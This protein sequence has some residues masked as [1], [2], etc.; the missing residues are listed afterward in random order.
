MSLNACADQLVLA[1]AD[2][3]TITSVTRLSRDPEGSTLWRAA[4]RVPFNHG[5]AEEV[6]RDRPD[7][8]IAGAYTTPATRALL[9][10]LHFPLL[11][12]APADSFEDIRRETRT[13]AAALGEADRGRA[14]IAHMDATLARLAA[15][16]GPPLR[17]AAWDGAGFSAAP[18]TLYDAI[19]KAAGARNVAGQATGLGGGT[20]DVETL[21]ALAPQLLVAGAPAFDRPGL[22]A[23]V[24][25]HPLVR[26]FW[27][28]RTLVVPLSAYACGTP[29]SADAAL[30]LRDQM[31]AMLKRARTPLPFAPT[32]A[33]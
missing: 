9:T 13:V 30:S 23:D 10:R 29:F 28:D 6:V 19:L 8:V 25:R 18:G 22:R 24:A 1:L 32:A 26:R 4:Q 7:L 2:P 27:A 3:G 20:P 33:R 5:L 15:D 17:V 16:R 11:V 14:L 21:I 31:R 12:L